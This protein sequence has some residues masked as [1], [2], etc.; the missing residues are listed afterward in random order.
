MSSI[1]VSYSLDEFNSCRQCHLNRLQQIPMTGIK[2]KK[3]EK[4]RKNNNNINKKK[5]TL[6]EEEEKE[7]EEE[8]EEEGD[9]KVKK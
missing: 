4:K 5:Q 9:M 7:E 6:S 1:V 3:K 2:R 8:Q